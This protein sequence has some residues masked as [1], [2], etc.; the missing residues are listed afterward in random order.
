MKKWK[1]NLG[2]FFAASVLAVGLAWI[3][4]DRIPSLVYF[5]NG[6]PVEIQGVLGNRAGTVSGF[7]PGTFWFGPIQ[8]RNVLG[9]P[10]FVAFDQNRLAK[11][12]QA[13]TEL[14]LQGRLVDFGPNSDF[15]AVRDFFQNKL[16]MIIPEH[17]QLLI[18]GENPRQEWRYPILFALAFLLLAG[19]LSRA[20]SRRT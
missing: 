17:A 13:F 18:V 1:L 5:F 9:Q 15:K 8:V 6:K 20:L 10:Y 7:L 16:G 2:Q 4:T 12:Y 19:F 3:F 11:K 14:K